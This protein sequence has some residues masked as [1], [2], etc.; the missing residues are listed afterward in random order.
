MGQIKRGDRPIVIDKTPFGDR[1]LSLDAYL[2]PAVRQRI[3]K[4]DVVGVKAPGF[5]RAG[6]ITEQQRVVIFFVI[7]VV[8]VFTSVRN[9]VSVVFLIIFLRENTLYSL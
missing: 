1:M 9:R 4:S 5:Q 6:D 7:L 3:T 2:H 8:S